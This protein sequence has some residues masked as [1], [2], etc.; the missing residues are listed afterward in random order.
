MDKKLVNF[1]AFL[2]KKIGPNVASFKS[3]DRAID[4]R[5][6]LVN[7]S[8][9]CI[10]PSSTKEVSIILSEANKK[11]VKLIP[12][13]GS[14]GLVGGQIADNNS[15]VSLSLEKMNGV[16]FSR[17][18]GLVNAQAGAIL[19]DIKRIVL[20]AGRIFPLSI[21]S[22]GSCQIGGNLATNAG[23]LNVIRYG[24]VRDLC[25]GI[26]AV[27]PSGLIVSSM[28]ALKKNNMG[29]DI[30]NLL[31]GS[32]GTLAVI[33]AAILK[34]FPLPIDPLVTLISVRDPIQAVEIFKRISQNFGDRLIA[35]ELMK[36]TGIQFLK[37][38]GYEVKYP[39]S[40]IA[41]WTVL[42]ELDINIGK[43]NLRE[44]IDEILA[45]VLEEKLAAEIVMSQNLEQKKEM[46]K[47]RELIPLA[48]RDIGSLCSNDI[49]IPI[50]KIPEFIKEADKGLLS[51]SDKIVVN[52]FGHIGDGNLHYN[53]FPLEGKF[54]ATLER[55]RLKIF[56][57]INDLVSNFS[58][59]ISAEHGI[60]RLKVDELA[61]YEDQGKLGAMLAIKTAIDPRD[62]L[63]PGVIFN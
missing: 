61:K 5:D 17:E 37:K 55:E 57:F 4:P 30:K 60:G 7:K 9:I 28:K 1:A 43:I 47:I 48:N 27:L 25:I 24:N 39:F 34:T 15:Q 32:E 26:E 10:K 8:E 21:A 62:I 38:T 20:D 11:N 40:K 59:S 6:R 36:N 44:E 13:G 51:I 50:G 46:W 53:I 52:C 19:S 63:N 58:G 31:I 16:S 22:E 56:R 12:V 45:E 2:Q 14:T 42:M 3:L 49:S 54:R 41:P 18:D 29:F 23:G 33:T 35:F